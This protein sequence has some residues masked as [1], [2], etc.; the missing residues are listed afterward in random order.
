MI[1]LGKKYESLL[2]PPPPPIIK[3]CEWGPWGLNIS[4]LA[5]KIPFLIFLVAVRP[6]LAEK[7]KINLLPI[8]HIKCCKCID[9]NNAI[10]DTIIPVTACV[11]DQPFG[12][13]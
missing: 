5:E 9:K 2:D 4:L 1:F 13:G 3:I 6:L 8:C 12:Q 10:E 7:L 11:E